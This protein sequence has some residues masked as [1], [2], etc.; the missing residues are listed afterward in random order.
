M[1]KSKHLSDNTLRLHTI[2]IMGN[3]KDSAFGDVLIEELK[4][5][6]EEFRIKSIEALGKLKYT[7]ASNILA[8]FLSDKYSFLEK[9]AAVGALG[10]IGNASI[11]SDLSALINKW[12]SDWIETDGPEL[13]W[14]AALALLKLGY[15]DLKTEKIIQNLLKRSYYEGNTLTDIYFNRPIWSCLL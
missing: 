10:N 4:S 5:E 11:I 1:S 7:A 14:E 2:M 9:L 6:K 15:V 8:E 13:R 3:S 12:P